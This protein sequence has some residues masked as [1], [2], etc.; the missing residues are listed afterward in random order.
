[1]GVGNNGKGNEK[2]AAIAT[3]ESYMGYTLSYSIDPAWTMDTGATTHLT[4]EMGKL[5][6]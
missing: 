3:Q 4:N 2:Q 5:S 1:M 6:S